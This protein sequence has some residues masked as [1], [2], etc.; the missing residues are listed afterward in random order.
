[1]ALVSTNEFRKKLKIMVDGQPYM[2]IDN[3][4][5]KPG[6]GQ[7]FNRVRIKNLVT[8]R[9]LERTWKSG[10]TVEEAEVSYTEMTYLYNDSSTWYFMDKKSMETMEISKEFMN[11][12]EQWLLEGADVEVTWW[13]GKP[14][15]V[16]PPTF[17]D[18][19]IVEAPPAVQ[20]NTSGNVMRSAILETGAEVMIPLFIEQGTKIRVDTRD[21]TYLERAK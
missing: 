4:F 7:A 3:Q 11:D 14:I 5:V 12:T 8:G 16:I 18:L 9:T 17:V 13:N 21:G 10:E 15:E 6:K 20:G 2:I 19:M 1:M